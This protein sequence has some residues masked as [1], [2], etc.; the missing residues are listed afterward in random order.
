MRQSLP[1]RIALV[2][3]PQRLVVET[4][5]RHYVELAEVAGYMLSSRLFQR[6]PVTLEV[7]DCSVSPYSPARLA[8]VAS[9]CHFIAMAVN[10]YNVLDAVKTASFL[11]SVNAQLLLV[12]YGSFCCYGSSH[13][14]ATRLFDNVVATGEW[15]LGL[16]VALLCHGLV[17]RP[18]LHSALRFE[19]DTFTMQDCT[20]R[21]KD[22]VQL[23][24]R[25]WGMPPYQHI[26]TADYLR[27]G[28]GVINL[29]V[30]RG[31][32]HKCRF[33]DEAYV[34]GC[35]FRYRPH[36]PVLR[37]LT[38]YPVGA[39]IAYLNA[40]AFTADREWVLGLCAALEE[41][42]HLPWRACT[43]LDL[44]DEPLIQM[45]A[46]AGCKRLSFGLESLEPSA[47][48]WIGK[49]ASTSTITDVVRWCHASGV[50]PR[51]L[52]ILGLPNQTASGIR[53]THAYLTRLGME[54]RYRPF[55]DLGRFSDGTLT[56][57]NLDDADRW[58]NPA[59]VAGM[60]AAEIRAL[61]FNL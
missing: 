8:A 54:I 26:P 5:F 59:E 44:V 15:E 12:A 21:L 14:S 13:L 37:F 60:S 48:D 34:A 19:A 27:V 46:R 10:P 38:D 3:P 50:T 30:A 41:Q 17:D 24:P 1:L 32:P 39:Q 4:L 43:R 20:I 6:H 55:L 9:R 28:E 40:S 61:E 18:A 22:G 33:C 31:C 35:R 25:E 49:R 56:L 36:S 45:M 42:A 29:R 51:A 58:S 16:E 53:E 2:W 23:D 11:K 47:Q 57:N 7:H 52:L